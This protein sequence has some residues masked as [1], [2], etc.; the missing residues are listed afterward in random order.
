MVLPR[1]LAELKHRKVYRAAVVYAAVGWA[2]LEAA[3]VVLPRLGL[4]DWTVDVVLA[5]VLLCFPLAIVFAWI[6]DLSPQGIVRTEPMSS[7]ARHHFSITSIVEF[8]VI[9]ILVATVG[10]LYL[11]RLSLQ[12]GIVELES[13][14]KDKTETSQPAVP[15]PEQYRAI[16]V[17]PFADMSEARDQDWFA[18]GVAEELLLALSQVDELKVTARTSSFAFKATDKTVA[19]IAD[20]LG[21]QAVLE[22]S[23]RRSG[24]QIRIAAQLVDASSGYHIWSGSYERRVADIFQLQD[25]IAKSI[26]E[27]LKLELGVDKNEALIPVST[28]NLEAY[29]AFIRGRAAL[30]FANP[31]VLTESIKYFEMAVAAD[32]DYADAWGYLAYA[33][34][35]IALWQSTGEISLPTIV[36]YQKALALDPHQSEALAVKGWMKQLLEWDWESAGRLYRQALASR[37]SPNAM[38]SY[39]VFYLPIIDEIPRAI[40]LLRDAER[41]DPLQAGIKSN[42]AMLHIWSGNP[43]AAIEKAKEALVLSPEHYFALMALLEAYILSGNCGLVLEIVDT[44]PESIR[45]EPR[46]FGRLGVCHALRG[47][48]DK[49]REIYK[50]VKTTTP[51]YY[52]NM[53][54]AALAMSLG[55][56]EDVLEI[57]EGEIEKHAWTSVFIRIYF[58]SN[59]L[60]RDNP[61]FLSILERIGLDDKSV[62]ELQEELTR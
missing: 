14:V 60:L 33:R 57:L 24:Q 37:D 27:T 18:E 34:G 5:V 44:L 39:G 58:G 50:H 10:Y 23:V 62:S 29:N 13:T 20:V 4:P 51:Y 3:D 19:E 30:D 1:F 52:A 55:E 47:E 26:V 42:L 21:V 6:F 56:V 16:A 11:D 48:E 2:L 43:Q 54:A 38:L 28:R 59:E 17:L 22:G 41:L 49:A 12:K 36:A 61:R 32:P 45:K 46:I 35:L 31:D 15:N 9:C 53:Q 40:N 8:A 7:E 25:E